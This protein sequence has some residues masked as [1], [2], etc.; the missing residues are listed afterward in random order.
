MLVGGQLSDTKGGNQESLTMRKMATSMVKGQ[1]VH[2]GWIFE[3]QRFESFADRRRD[4]GK[5][6]AL[7]S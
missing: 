6:L 3:Q 1:G 2:I 4:Q 7:F 5:C